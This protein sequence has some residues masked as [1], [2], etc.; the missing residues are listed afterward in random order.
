MSKVEKVA[1][2]RKLDA[3]I[4]RCDHASNMLR[5]ASDLIAIHDDYELAEIRVKAANAALSSTLNIL[6]QTLDEIK[7]GEK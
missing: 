2:L 5:M 1:V 7:A 3:A 4:R 6:M